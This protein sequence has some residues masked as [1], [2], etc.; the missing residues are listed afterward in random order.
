MII[1]TFILLNNDYKLG[2]IVEKKL[3]WKVQGVS[4]KDRQYPITTLGYL[5]TFSGTSCT[6]GIL[7]H[8]KSKT[9]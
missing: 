4:E 7:L 8:Y 3:F 1:Y 2:H 9:G 5:L 6:T